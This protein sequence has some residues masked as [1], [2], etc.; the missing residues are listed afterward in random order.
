LNEKEVQVSN[1]AYEAPYGLEN[2]LRDVVDVLE[3][4]GIALCRY[5]SKTDGKMIEGNL[6]RSRHR[7]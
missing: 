1:A 3:T 5:G 2:Q 7:K 4:D 6:A